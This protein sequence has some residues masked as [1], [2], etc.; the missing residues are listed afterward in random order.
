MNKT[1]EAKAM[2]RRQSWVALLGVM[3][4]L[5]VSATAHAQEAE[6]AQEPESTAA[7]PEATGGSESSSPAA[8]VDEVGLQIGRAEMV[9]I[10]NEDPESAMEF[11]QE[12]TNA[13]RHEP[14]LHYLIGT[15]LF[16]LE[17][18]EEAA[19]HF[20]RAAEA[21]AQTDPPL[22]LHALYGRGRVLVAAGEI[23]QAAEAYGQYAAY[24]R[25]HSDVASHLE[26]AEA[27]S[28]TLRARAQSTQ[29]RRSR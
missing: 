29:R 26:L 16:R 2:Q 27:M 11:A 17:R 20:R 25:T 13:G 3:V 24:A 7:P 14:R 18:Y 21:T 4:L 22:H 15:C 23:A 9:L 6:T 19:D 5:G 10:E 12:V 8:A 1:G 28:A